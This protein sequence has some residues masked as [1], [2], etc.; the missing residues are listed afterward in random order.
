MSKLTQ[1]RKALE[2]N[3]SITIVGAPERNHLPSRDG[4]WSHTVDIYVA[5]KTDGVYT[6]EG[7]QTLMMS[8]VPELEQTCK[9]N[10]SEGDYSMSFGMLYFDEV[11]G[12]E[13]VRREMVLSDEDMFSSDGFTDGK[14]IIEY[15]NDVKRRTWVRL[16]PN[17]EIATVALLGENQY[18]ISKK[19]LAKYLGDKP[20]GFL[21]C[22]AKGFS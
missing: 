1:V 7:L 13:A 11:I 17:V 21:A 2:D 15:V 18:E 19:D 6:V 14:L 16:F 12:T 3:P 8:L 5:P 4:Y 10:F 22:L 20:R 9:D